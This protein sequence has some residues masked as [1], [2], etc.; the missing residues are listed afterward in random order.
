MA[1]T[2]G[3]SVGLIACGAHANLYAATVHF[4]AQFRCALQNL[5]G[6]IFAVECHFIF[7]KFQR[8]LNAFLVSPLVT[9]NAV[10]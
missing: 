10:A 7:V 4:E 3:P 9:R 6:N 1:G 2:A 8:P 5:V